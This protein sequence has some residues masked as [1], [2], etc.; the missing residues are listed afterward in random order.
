MSGGVS[1]LIMLFIFLIVTS[2]I[3][4]P[5]SR[6]EGGRS[7][8]RL[9]KEFNGVFTGLGILSPA[10]L[11]FRYGSS[12]VTFTATRKEAKAVLSW[13][14]TRLTCEVISGRRTRVNPRLPE[15]N[16]ED[17][18]VSEAFRVHADD[19]AQTV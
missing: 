19:P 16:P 6:R 7:W 8:R 4:L 9:A 3:P 17:A 12:R 2:G 11:R 14:D 5:F 13:P 1:F 18:K 15:V 10:V